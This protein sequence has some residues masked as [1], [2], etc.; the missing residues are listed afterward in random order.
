[1]VL[2]KV[3]GGEAMNLDGIA[4]DVA[5]LRRPVVVVHGANALR[6][7]LAAQL[8][9]DKRVVTSVS[10]YDSVYSDEAAIDLL[11]L[12]YAGLRNKR[13]VERLQRH[14]ANAI[15]LSG[16]DGRLV[17]G[18]RN[19]GIRVREG[20]KTLLLRDFS[21]KPSAVNEPLLRLLLENG[22]TPVLTVPLVDERGFAI[23]SEN[24]E[25]IALLQRVLRASD[26]V[27]LIEA[28][29]L[30]RD[31]GDPASVIRS[32]GSSELPGLQ[33]RARGRFKRKLLA[34]ARLFEAGS[35]RVMIADGRVA[36]PVSA[37]LSGEGTTI[38]AGFVP[39]GLAPAEGCA[40]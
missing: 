9:Q 11:M 3:G 5:A 27:E 24:D 32:L 15:G 31:P 10:G 12:A 28:P 30:L 26:V 4:A 20:D 34:L 29:G 23:N 36:H 1:M 2:V 25:V 21:G 7:R 18:T 8:G 33:E 38:T 17:Q 39:S 16:L 40:A 14:G 35:P 6:D 37:A 19:K 13:L 22:Y